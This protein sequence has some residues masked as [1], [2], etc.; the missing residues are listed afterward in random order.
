ME[1][2]NGNPS[3]SNDLLCSMDIETT[4]KIAIWDGNCDGKFLKLWRKITICDG[5]LS[6]TTSFVTNL[7]VMGPS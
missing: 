4:K 7:I 2:K 3:N 5:K 1:S 6:V